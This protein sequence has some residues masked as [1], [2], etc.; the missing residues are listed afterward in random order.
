MHLDYLYKKIIKDVR[1]KA[2]EGQWKNFDYKDKAEKCRFKKVSD[3]LLDKKP[4]LQELLYNGLPTGYYK[5]CSCATN[6]D[7]HII[8]CFD[9]DHTRFKKQNVERHFRT[10]SHLE[11]GL[12]KV[13][14]FSCHWKK[15]MNRKYLKLMATQRVSGKIFRSE[16]FVDILVSWI[17]Q[18]TNSKVDAKTVLD[19]LPS[20]TTLRRKMLELSDEQSGNLFWNSCRILQYLIDQVVYILQDLALLLHSFIQIIFLI[21]QDPAGF[22]L[23][24]YYL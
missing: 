16:T 21:L 7:L 5:C 3:W 8:K 6:G 11:I 9:E 15:E 24:E 12:G 17:N 18:V 19:Q 4:H 10:R 1:S 2:I 22:N 23:I 13:F 14:S 20:R